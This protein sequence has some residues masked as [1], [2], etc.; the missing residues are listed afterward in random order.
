[1]IVNCVHTIDEKKIK[2]LLK[3]LKYEIY[4]ATLEMR[5][6]RV[7]GRLGVVSL[8]MNKIIFDIKNYNNIHL[9]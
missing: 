5:S 8:F 2:I 6:S 7:Q 9:D 4:L 3:Y 1:M